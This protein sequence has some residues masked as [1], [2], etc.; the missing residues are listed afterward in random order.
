MAG[1]P[2]ELKTLGRDVY[3]HAW[4]EGKHPRDD[5]GKFGSGGGADGGWNEGQPPAESV[6]AGGGQEGQPTEG[7]VPLPPP[8]L[9]PGSPFG[10]GGS[11]GPPVAPAASGGRFGGLTSALNSMFGKMDAMDAI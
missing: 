8:A 3:G 6:G 1:L 2:K 10:P 4:E 7:S 9:E 11:E 5:D